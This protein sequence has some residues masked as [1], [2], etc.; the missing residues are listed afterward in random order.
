MTNRQKLDA[1]EASIAA[2]QEQIRSLATKDGELTQ[3]ESD[4]LRSL[5][6]TQDAELDARDAVKVEVDKDEARSVRVAAVESSVRA[7]VSRFEPGVAPN[8]I[9]KPDTLDVLSDRSATPQQLADA[10]TRS[11]EPKVENAENMAHVRSVLNRHRSDR[12]WARGLLARSTDAYESAFYKLIS[13]RAWDISPEERT[14]LSTMTSANGDYL[15]PIHLDPTII[16]TNSGSSNVMRQHAT[17]KTLTRPGDTSWQGVSSAGITASWDGQL[18]EVS[19]DSPTFAQPTI[20]I[21]KAQAL[22]QASIELTE[23]AAGLAGELLVL[24]GDARDRLEGA[25]HMTG[26]GTNEPWGLFSALDANTNVEIVSDT[27]AALFKAD[28]NEVYYSVPVR[29]RGKSKWFMNPVWSLAIQD[30]GT[31][32]SA[33]YSTNLAQGTSPTILGHQVVET[34][35]APTTATTTVRDNRLVFGD[36]SQYYIVD[37]PGSFSVE[38]IPHLFNTN[39]NLPDGRR[40]WYCYWRTGGDSVVDTA[41]RL[42]QDKTSA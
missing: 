42:L 25:A 30:L 16:L 1:L 32:L 9:R 34:D 31:A 41:F 38:F 24:F 20:A 37:K 35:D 40:A 27:A 26:S 15:V 2:R 6:E 23:D 36:P 5:N 3:D 13:G 33:N 11:V 28:L 12:E 14:A 17:I 29:F 21:H 22:A 39:A 8:V 19:D 18:A 7:G 10:V 4:E